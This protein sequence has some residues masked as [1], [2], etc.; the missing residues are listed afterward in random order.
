MR[1]RVR[2]QL[3][4]RK[5]STVSWQHGRVSGQESAPQVPGGEYGVEE[6]GTRNEASGS[7]ELRPVVVGHDARTSP[8][9]AIGVEARACE[10]AVLGMLED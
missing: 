7:H 8:F 3:G 4:A 6:R 9:F 1:L 5:K 2:V 10:E